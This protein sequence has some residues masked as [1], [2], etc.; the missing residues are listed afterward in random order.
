MATLTP[1]QIKL[2]LAAAQ[3]L[4]A[5]YGTN[6]P[7]MTFEDGVAAALQW[8]L[9]EGIEPLTAPYVGRQ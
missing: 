2:E 9:G 3:R 7:D 5:T 8:I 4:K 1:E 6:A